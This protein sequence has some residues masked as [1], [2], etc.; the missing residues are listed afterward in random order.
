MDKNYVLRLTLSLLV[1][2]TTFVLGAG[3]AQLLASRQSEPELVLLDVSARE[4]GFVCSPENYLELRVYTSGRVEGDVPS[5]SCPPGLVR[6]LGNNILDYYLRI[7]SSF[8]RRSSQL[9]A[10]QLAQLR[11]VLNQPELAAVKESYPYFVIQ[12]DSATF[13]TIRF[14]HAGQQQTVRLVNSE[15][16]DPR[17]KANYPPSLIKLLLEAKQIRQRWETVAK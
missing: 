14:E 12:T 15:P 5:G 2:A 8:E 6:A 13:Q 4:G 3:A 9:D 10:N 16:T 11:A 1:V 7:F 17:N